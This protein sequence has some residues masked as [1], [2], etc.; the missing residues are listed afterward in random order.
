MNRGAHAYSPPPN[1]PSTS[2]NQ[3]SI[4]CYQNFGKGLRGVFEATNGDDGADNNAS[5]LNSL[6]SFNHSRKLT[7]DNE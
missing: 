4:R 3:Y 5:G 1:S 6:G 7:M 2:A